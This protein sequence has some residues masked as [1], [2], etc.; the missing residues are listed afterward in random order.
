[1]I[2]YENRQLRS[3]KIRIIIDK[4]PPLWIRS[5]ITILF[6]LLLCVFFIITNL[7][8]KKIFE[9]EIEL[10]RVENSIWEGK[11]NIP[12]SYRGQV[13]ENMPIAIS[14]EKEYKHMDNVNAYIHNTSDSLTGFNDK[15]S[16]TTTIWLDDTDGVYKTM[17]ADK[18][19]GYISLLSKQK[20]IDYIMIR[21][22]E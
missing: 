13:V 6:G 14:V 5:G 7:P 11:V 8:Y 3:E 10:K 22:N 9:T 1:M 2:D 12:N 21:G 16:F 20:L 19:I 18:I 15:N 17:S 4:I